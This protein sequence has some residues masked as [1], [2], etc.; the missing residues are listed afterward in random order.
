[1]KLC[2]AM[3]VY[4]HKTTE[5]HYTSGFLHVYIYVHKP[6]TQNTPTT[7]IYSLVGHMYFPWS[8]VIMNVHGKGK[9]EEKYVW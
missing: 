8:H 6:T 3:E 1:M 2:C 9:R 4:F 5:V 7:N